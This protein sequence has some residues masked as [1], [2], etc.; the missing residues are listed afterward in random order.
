MSAGL[1]CPREKGEIMT[2]GKTKKEQAATTKQPESTAS[3][4]RGSKL[5]LKEG[6]R[7]SE[8]KSELREKVLGVFQNFVEAGNILYEIRRDHLWREEHPSYEEFC[9]A[10]WDYGRNYADKLIRAANV[11]NNLTEHRE[12]LERA[13]GTTVPLP[14]SETQV[15]GLVRLAPNEQVEIWKAVVQ[16][17]RDDEGQ[18]HITAELVEEV[19]TRVKGPPA[20]KKS[21]L[22]QPKVE[23]DFDENEGAL[24]ADGFLRW[25]GETA[26]T[27]G[28][29]LRHIR[30]NELFGSHFTSIHEVIVAAEESGDLLGALQEADARTASKRKKPGQHGTGPKTSARKPRQATA[31][32]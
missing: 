16:E 20:T 5:T 11:V 12:E 22:T 4:L 27:A 19:T 25:W 32:A 15:R 31:T 9:R 10:E 24:S 17:A 28:E 6:E 7:Y 26:K 1:L 18:F 29:N 21:R 2:K 3:A 8:L 30:D 23:D 13:L 14:A